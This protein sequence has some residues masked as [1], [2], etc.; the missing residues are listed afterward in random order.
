MRSRRTIRRGGFGSR[1][2]AGVRGLRIGV[3]ETEW[4]DAS[5]DVARAGKQAL[6]EL[7]RAGAVLVGTSSKRFM[8]AA[9]TG[10][11]GGGV[12]TFQVERMA[13]PV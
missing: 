11:P 12:R 1:I 10:W 4:E 13:P 7:E 5:P 8:A 9:S 2:G 6:A 3:A